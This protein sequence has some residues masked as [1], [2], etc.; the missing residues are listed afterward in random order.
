MFNRSR[1]RIRHFALHGVVAF[2]GIV[3]GLSPAW[4]QTDIT[5]A[6][7]PHTADSVLFEWYE[8]YAP[9]NVS[10]NVLG[11]GY[12]SWHSK[13]TREGAAFPHWVTIDFGT[14]RIVTQLNI[15][16]YSESYDTNLRLKDFRFEGSVDGNTYTPLHQGFL[17]YA[18]QH[19]WQS[20]YF[21]NTAGYRYYRLFGL[22]NWGCYDV[23]EQMI[24]EEWEMFEG[25]PVPA[26]T[27]SW[28]TIKARFT[29]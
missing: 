17:Q 10:N 11:L 2:L 26:Q 21:Q 18:N 22:S 9:E 24:I 27:T 14:P 29:K 8:Y 4:S 25:G 15:L 3:A 28:G 12:G 19:D 16:A 6:G 1:S 7:L 23:C 20:F 5:D 13:D